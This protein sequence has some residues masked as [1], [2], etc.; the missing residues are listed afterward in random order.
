MSADAP[1]TLKELQGHFQDFVLGRSRTFE[2]EVA[3]TP[4]GDSLQRLLIYS[5]SYNLRL[6]EA[7]QTDY[8][9]LHLVL[10]D[11][12]FMTMAQRYIATYPSEH[13]SIRWFGRKLPVFLRENAPWSGTDYLH[14]LA[15]F[16]WALSLCFDAT[17]TI[18]VGVEEMS[19]IP[20]H[21]WPEL[22]FEFI[23]SL[24]RLDL[25]ND[26]TEIRKADESN[27]APVLPPI[28]SQDPVGWI[29]WRDGLISRYRSMAV[30]E[31]ISLD[32][33]GNGA[34]F[35]ELCAGLCEWMDPTHAAARAASLL[36]T[37]TGEGLISRALTADR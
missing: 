6:I 37:W 24:Q 26:V 18:P 32:S 3:E 33:A 29:V 8:S 20:P 9:A 15:S 27:S 31:A 14:E 11:R 1:T 17:D 7:L 2:T 34:N 21:A 22:R 10:G 28:R 19:L 16:E 13:P 12:Q 5:Q 4:G 36:K 25:Q 30:D 35:A 23:P